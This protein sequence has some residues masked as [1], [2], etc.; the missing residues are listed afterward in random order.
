MIESTDH[1]AA[2]ISV[3]DVTQSLWEGV[4]EAEQEPNFEA[5]VQ[6]L[7]VLLRFVFALITRAVAQTSDLEQISEG[8]K[9]YVAACDATLKL[10][11][12][13]KKNLQLDGQA[14]TYNSILE[15]RKA[16]SDRMNR[17][18]EE[19]ECEKEIPAGLFPEAI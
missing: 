7:E 17:A 12:A 16:A 3:K 18:Q 1:Q 2:T 6:K 10:C 9:S 15:L 19:L 8:W 5:G 11:E 13:I 14:E 4:K